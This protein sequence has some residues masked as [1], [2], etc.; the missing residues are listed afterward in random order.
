MA[1]VAA[2]AVMAPLDCPGL[3]RNFSM[4]CSILE[5]YGPLLDLPELWFP[6]LE[7][8][9]QAPPLDIGQ[10]EVP[11]LVK[12]IKADE[13]DWQIYYSRQMGK[14]FDQNMPRI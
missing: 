9:L 14:I 4:V 11:E 7:G 13:E 12:L 8:V 6:E 10:G 2:A 5:C 3:C 1:T